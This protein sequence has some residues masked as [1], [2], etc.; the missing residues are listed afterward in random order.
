VLAESP[1]GFTGRTM[2]IGDAAGDWAK[3]EVSYDHI[4][5]R[6]PEP[7]GTSATNFIA[8]GVMGVFTE[9]LM[10]A[11]VPDDP[12]ASTRYERYLQVLTDTTG[13][14]DLERTKTLLRDHGAGP[15]RASICK[16]A[17]EFQTLGSVIFRP[18]QRS[19][20]IAKGRPCETDYCEV[21]L[22]D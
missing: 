15:G 6:R 22:F 11:L 18:A 21:D 1:R 3:V 12:D 14:I 10:H 8:V 13:D 4:A 16:H 2:I 19:A 20:L 7:T 9:P 17:P 5:V